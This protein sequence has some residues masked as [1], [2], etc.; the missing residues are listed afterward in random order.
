[1]N[2]YSIEIV[3]QR[4]NQVD[5]LGPLEDLDTPT[6]ERVRGIIGCSIE[7]PAGDILFEKIAQLRANEEI[8]T[9]CRIIRITQPDVLATILQAQLR[10]KPRLR[11]LHSWLTQGEAHSRSQFWLREIKNFGEGQNGPECLQGPYLYEALQKVSPKCERIED[12]LESLGGSYVPE[13]WEQQEPTL[14]EYS[15]LVEATNDANINHLL[16]DF[17]GK[18]VLPSGEIW[19]EETIR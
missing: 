1:M 19:L 9:I 5:I 12:P 15:L 6:F 16:N 18:Q 10:R 11:Q 13:S 7:I 14:E 17:F 3:E 2:K 8:P 4:P